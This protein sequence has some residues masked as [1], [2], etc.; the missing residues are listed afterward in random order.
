MAIVWDRA[1][2]IHLVRRTHFGASD[3]EI[4]RFL[5]Y[6]SAASAMNPLFAFPRRAA[7]FRKKYP[8]LEE[9]QRWW[10]NRMIKKKNVFQ[11]RL[12]LFLH[13]HFATSNGKLNSPRL[14]AAQNGLLREGTT[15]PFDELLFEISRDPAMIYWLDNFT[16]VK[17]NP[18]ERTHG[19]C[20]ADPLQLKQVGLASFFKGSSDCHCTVVTGFFCE[21]FDAGIIGTA[22]IT[23]E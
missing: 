9:V 6:G 5:G 11:E 8:E 16:N 19:A 21:S 18:N 7:R 1:N 22:G 2:V 17:G 20:N 15:L 10:L 3:R 13:D 14:M 23:E 12:T 4:N